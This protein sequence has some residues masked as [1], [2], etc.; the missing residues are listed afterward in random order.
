MIY[1]KY[2]F[3]VP[4]EKRVRV[5]TDSDAKNEADDQ[6]AIVHSL[7]SPKMENTGVVAAHFG[8]QKSTTSMEDS[9]QEILKILDLMD[10]D[11]SLAYHGAKEALPDEC[12]PVPSEGAE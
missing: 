4:D 10:I 5:I 8:K 2:S 6:Y 9:F 3:K 1:D 12:T 7:L 11:S